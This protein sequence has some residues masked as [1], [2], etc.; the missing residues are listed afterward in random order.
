MANIRVRKE[1]G[2]LFLDFRYRNKR[3]R[4]QTAL[5]DTPINRRKL[6]KVLEKIEAEITLGSLEYARYFP[7]S[8]MAEEMSTPL[9]QQPIA[10][11]PLFEEFS[12]TWLAEMKIQWR[13]SHYD[14]VSHTI[15]KY[16]D[17]EF[18]DN[19]ISCISKA[20][21]LTFRSSLGTACR[22]VLSAW[23]A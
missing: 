7:N 20:D 18:G 1:T 13:E 12:A 10:K 11:T 19:E 17:P 4:E 23:L 6:K 14:T 15:K 9:H 8:T 5:D 2:K 16:L 3:C 21:V 22:V